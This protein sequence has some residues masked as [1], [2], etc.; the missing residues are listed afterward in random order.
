M[1]ADSKQSSPPLVPSALYFLKSPILSFSTYARRFQ[2]VH[3]KREL[4]DVYFGTKSVKSIHIVFIIH[5]FF[6]KTLKTLEVTQWYSVTGIVLGLG[7]PIKTEA[8]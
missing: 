7:L 1:E 5:I 3:G 6:T 8:Y 4:K 2:R